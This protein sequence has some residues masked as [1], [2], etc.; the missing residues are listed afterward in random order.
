[1]QTAIG[2]RRVFLVLSL[3]LGLFCLPVTADSLSSAEAFQASAELDDQHQITIHWR[4]A[5]GHYLYQ[6]KMSF[7]LAKTP[8]ATLGDPQWPAGEIKDDKYFG[9]QEVYRNQVSIPMALYNSA[10]TP[11]TLLVKYQGC[12]DKGICYPPKKVSFLLTPTTTAAPPEPDTQ[13]APATEE[14]RITSLLSEGHYLT[15]IGVF[16]IGGLA[17]TFTPCVLP[18][19]PILSSIIVGQKRDL[20][21]TESFSL[22]LSYVLGMAITYS[23]LGII[24]G[25]AGTNIMAYLQNPWVISSFAL[26]FVLLSLSMFGLYELQLPQGLQSRL[27][28][29]T[30]QQRGGTLAGTM[31]MGILSALVV[32]PC[33]SAPLAGALV[34]ISTT[35][36]GALLGGTAL[37]SLAMGMGTPLLIIGTGGTHLIP[38]AGAWMNGVKAFFGVMLLG[39]AIWFLDRIVPP[40]VTLALLGALVL[41]CGVYLG[42]LDFSSKSGWAQ[43][44]KTLGFLSVLYGSL[45]WIGAA[46]GSQNPLQPL[47]ALVA[48]HSAELTQP[49][50]TA[51]KTVVSAEQLDR[52]LALAREQN[53]P[54]VLDFYADWCASCKVMEHSVFPKPSV[55]EK[56]EKFYLIQADVTDS[57]EL[58]ER[59]NLFGPP[60]LLFFDAQGVALSQYHIRSEIKAPALASHLTGV[61]EASFP[62][63]ASTS[64]ELAANVHP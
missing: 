42:G 19:I 59:Y 57:S 38:Q 11:I 34:Y 47:T 60:S 27:N 22:S 7:A 61:L 5:E 56:L 62:G 16:F 64:A 35:D 39:V 1:M 8:H 63:E 41:G 55:A 32:S 2:Y 3:L 58:L 21:K 14:H 17:L 44:R 15:I 36:G 48:S 33:V 20:K 30:G 40:T 10:L 4:I 6:S 52:H 54:V 43:L 13:S 49:S 12:A 28:R 23:L 46:A 53:L 18:M 51:F 31:L 29:I 45:L 26:L 37:F 50:A 9:T 24:L 25:V